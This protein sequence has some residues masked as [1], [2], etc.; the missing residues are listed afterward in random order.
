M[1]VRSRSAHNTCSDQT[2]K[3]LCEERRMS[4][5]RSGLMVI[6]NVVE[7]WSAKLR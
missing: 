2:S 7:D 6:R 4:M 5:S 1:D 3:L